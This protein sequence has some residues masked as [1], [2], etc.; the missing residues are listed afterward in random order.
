MTVYFITGASGSGKTAIIPALKQTLGDAVALH[1]FDDIGVP[2]HADKAWRQASTEQ[3]LQKLLCEK[4]EVCLLGQMVLGELL[5]CPSIRWLND[6]H[7]CLLDVND[8]ERVVR[9]KKRNTGHANQTMLNW[10]SWQRMHTRDPQWEQHVIKEACWPGLDFSSW[11]N[12]DRWDP[13]VDI[14]LLDTTDDSIQ[15]VAESVVDWMQVKP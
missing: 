13:H 7:F 14:K 12:L 6:I 9:L 11:D 1:D 5:A 10:A 3:W 15:Q 8:D 2:S 4:K